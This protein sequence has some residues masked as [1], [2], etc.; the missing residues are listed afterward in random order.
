M[1]IIDHRSPEYIKFRGVLVNNSY[2]STVEVF[3]EKDNIILKYEH[4]SLAAPGV[5][6]RATGFVQRSSSSILKVAAF[7]TIFS[8]IIHERCTATLEH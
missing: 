5:N 2:P 7:D 1:R 8:R 4:G 3:N 6:I